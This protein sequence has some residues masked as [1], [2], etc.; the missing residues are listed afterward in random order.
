MCWSKIVAGHAVP[1]TPTSR[2]L[3]AHLPLLVTARMATGTVLLIHTK[4]LG[5]RAGGSGGAMGQGSPEHNF[6]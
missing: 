1:D 2:I 3:P 4:W 5:H 6:A